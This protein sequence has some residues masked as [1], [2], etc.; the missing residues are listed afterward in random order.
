MGNIQQKGHRLWAPVFFT[1]FFSLT[2]LYLL[3]KE[4]AHFVRLRQS[5]LKHGDIGVPPQRN[6][7]ILVENVPKEYRSSEKLMQLFET[8]FPGEVAYASIA[9]QMKVL[10]SCVE[11]RKIALV[12]AEKIVAE[13]MCGDSKEPPTIVLFR[14]R[15]LEGIHF[16]CTG[17]LE[18]KNALEFYKKQILDYNAL[19]SRYQAEVRAADS[20]LPMQPAAMDAGDSDEEAANA[21]DEEALLAEG[22]ERQDEAH[23]EVDI[24]SDRVISLAGNDL[25]VITKK[26]VSGTGFVTFKSRRAQ[27]TATQV[28][29]LSQKYSRIKAYPAPEPNDIVWQNITVPTRYI[30]ESMNVTHAMYMAGILFWAGILAFIAALSNLENLEK[31]LPF[32]KS[33][34]PVLYAIVAGLLPVLVL[35]IFMSLLPVIMTLVSELIEK[36]KTYSAIHTEVL[37]W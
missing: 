11:K 22:D 32:I 16:P 2:L 18:T 31:Y 27:A 37:K 20:A 30:E 36:Q 25:P 5:F 19:I 14:G 4:Y 35:V 3:H 34:D 33:M 9:V 1:Y 7:S 15:P 13:Y 29:R 6:Y 28:I 8:L 26:Q 21:K 12:N 24:M 23:S 17:K 10:S